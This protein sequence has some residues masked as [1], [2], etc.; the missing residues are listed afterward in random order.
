[1]SQ[2]AQPTGYF[3]IG[4]E[5]HITQENIGTLWR[6][7][8]NMGASFIFTIGKK[9]KKQTSDTVKAYAS[10]PLFQYDDF[11][12]FYNSFPKDCRLVGIEI[13]DNAECLS[14]FKH[15]DRC[16][17]LL[18][19][20]TNGLTQTAIE[21]CHFIVKIPTINCINVSVSG[22]IVMYDRMIKQ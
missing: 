16:V 14:T 2:R 6:S 19:S 8:Y 15:P 4:I 10:I 5:H 1:M 13:T 12:S 3:G 17:Y 9:Y 21:H 11:E 22:S 20:E 7:A 18:G